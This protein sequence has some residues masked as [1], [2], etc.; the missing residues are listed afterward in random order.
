LYERPVNSNNSNTRSVQNIFSI[1]RTIFYLCDSFLYSTQ[2]KLE[3]DDQDVL[4]NNNNNLECGSFLKGKGVLA[5][6]LKG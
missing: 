4:K 1:N 6:G 2:F 5:G 3:W